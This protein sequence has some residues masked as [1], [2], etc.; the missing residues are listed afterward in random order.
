MKR[1]FYCFFAT[2]IFVFSLFFNVGCS[3]NEV[4]KVSKNLTTYAIN[5]KFEELDT[6]NVYYFDG[7]TWS[8]VG[9]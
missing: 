7:T 8:K 3:S 1:F 4:E 2:I 6:G 5:A 9:G